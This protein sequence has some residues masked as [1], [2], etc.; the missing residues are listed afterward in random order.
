MDEI[1]K[2][3]EVGDRSE[4]VTNPFSGVSIELDPAEAAVYD[5]IRGAE[6]IGD[7]NNIGKCK[8]WFEK[9]NPKAYSIL[10]DYGYFSNE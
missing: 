3:L 9:K 8:D 4:K 1:L 10:I 7:M 2:E 6:M 5:Y